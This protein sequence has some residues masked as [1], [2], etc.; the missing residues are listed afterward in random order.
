MKTSL[1]IEEGDTVVAEWTWLGTNTGPLITLDGSEI[2]ATGKT[3][4][5][6]GVSVLTVRDGKP[7]SERDYVDTAAMTSQL[8]LMA[9]S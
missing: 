6:S 1:L 4:E 8:R 2:P 7:A 9:G 5:L 3:V